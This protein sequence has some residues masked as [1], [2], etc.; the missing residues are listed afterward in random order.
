MITCGADLAF[1]TAAARTLEIL[2]GKNKVLAGQFE[3]KAVSIKLKELDR[4]TYGNFSHVF[5]ISSWRLP[6]IEP[7]SCTQKASCILGGQEGVLRVLERF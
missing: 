1:R 3:L 6:I 4:M 5:R 7:T 2:S